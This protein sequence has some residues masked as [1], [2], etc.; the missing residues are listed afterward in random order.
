MTVAVATATKNI[1]KH[2]TYDHI[3][4]KYK[5]DRNEEFT[6]FQQRRN[7]AWTEYED[8]TDLST[9]VD[10][11]VVAVDDVDGVRFLHQRTDSLPPRWQQVAA[12][13]ASLLRVHRT[14]V[15]LILGRRRRLL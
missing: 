15:R 5:N 3:L 12:P 13:P 14:D 10:S 4:V 8:A 1:K 2:R 11:G 7:T 6:Q 9:D